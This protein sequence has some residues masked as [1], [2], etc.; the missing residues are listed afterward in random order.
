MRKI[1]E[2]QRKRTPCKSC[3]KPRDGAG[4]FA[5]LRWLGILGEVASN[6]GFAGRS[7]AHKQGKER[8]FYAGTGGHQQGETEKND[9]N[10]YENL[11]RVDEMHMSYVF[12]I[13]DVWQ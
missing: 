3:G 9:E 1:S 2:H 5:L 7:G 4:E 13:F 6:S 12:M 8:L 11:M 10:F